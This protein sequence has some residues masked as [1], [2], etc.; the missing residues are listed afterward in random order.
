MF[1]PWKVVQA[2]RCGSRTDA[3]ALGLP[4]LNRLLPRLVE[5]VHKVWLRKSACE[6]GLTQITSDSGG[7]L[8]TTL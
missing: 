6:R 1:S 4:A 8:G 3:V 7:L 2:G 5:E